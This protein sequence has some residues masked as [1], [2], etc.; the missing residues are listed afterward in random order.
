MSNTFRLKI[1]SPAGTAFDANVTSAT[2]PTE[3]GQVQVLANHCRY[4]GLLTEGEIIYQ[5]AEDNKASG[6]SIKVSAGCITFEDD[7]LKVLAQSVN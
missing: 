2:L 4:V 1:I 6:N 3:S 5:S 7:T